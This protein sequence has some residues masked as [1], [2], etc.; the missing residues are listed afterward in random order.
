MERNLF[1]RV[2]TCFPINDEHLRNRVCHQGIDAFLKDNTQAWI[3]NSDASYS[4][5]QPEADDE[6]F[7]AQRYLV[8]T[9]TS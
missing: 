8:E 7:S 5:I 6:V 3:L 2:E 4:R 1:N 9:V